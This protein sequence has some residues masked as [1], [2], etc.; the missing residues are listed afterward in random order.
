M[1]ELVS[2]DRLKRMAK[3]L[4]EA[5]DDAA[6]VYEK[7]SRKTC[8]PDRR[9]LANEMAGIASALLAVNEEWEK[10]T[11]KSKPVAPAAG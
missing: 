5:F 3:A 4:G 1:S 9:K 11:A 10:R 7:A 8:H 6:G 2:N